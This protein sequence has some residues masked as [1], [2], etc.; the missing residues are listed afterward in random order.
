MGWLRSPICIEK[1]AVSTAGSWTPLA[2]HPRSPPV[3]FVFVSI[4]TS[5]ATLAKSSPFFKR[6]RIVLA[7]ASSATTIWRAHTSSCVGATSFP[8]ASES[9]VRMI[10][11]Y[12]NLRISVSEILR[13]FMLTMKLETT[14]LNPSAVKGVEVGVMVGVSVIV[15]VWLMAAVGEDSST[16]EVGPLTVGV[17]VAGRGV[18]VG[19]VVE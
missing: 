18:L 15:G 14:V 12:R 4:D 3:F 16:V 19:P 6:V 13:G 8:T 17:A 7:L 1:A 9:F 2:N 11:L 10:W 5:A